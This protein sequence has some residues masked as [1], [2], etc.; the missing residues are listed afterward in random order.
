LQ[1]NSELNTTFDFC[2]EREGYVTLRMAAW[3]H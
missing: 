3:L 1:A 2:F